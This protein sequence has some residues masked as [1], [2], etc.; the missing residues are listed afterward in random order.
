[1]GWGKNA[2]AGTVGNASTFMV[3]SYTKAIAFS[4]PQF[5]TRAQS[6]FL[7]LGALVLC[8]QVYISRGHNLRSFVNRSDLL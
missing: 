5:L 3:L 2:V 8:Y 7:A 4:S 6:L 1:M